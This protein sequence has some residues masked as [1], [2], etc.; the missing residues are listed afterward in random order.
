VIAIGL[1]DEAGLGFTRLQMDGTLMDQEL[2]LHV[3]DLVNRIVYLR[4][5]L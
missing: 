1:V 3:Q 4:D 5:S 2:K